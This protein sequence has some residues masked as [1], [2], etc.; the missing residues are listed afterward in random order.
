MK[1]RKFK[2]NGIEI[3]KGSMSVKASLNMTRFEKQFQQAQFWLDG[4]IMNDMVPFM[5]M[6]DDTFID[7]TKMHSAALQGSGKVYA[8]YGPQGR[9]LYEGKVMV[10]ELTK[11]PWARKGARKEVIDKDLK[12][13]RASAKPKWFEEAE[14]LNSSNWIKGVKER[15]G[16]S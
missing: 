1:L 3:N 4:Q 15:A 2:F 10:D 6:Q 9:F 16:G 8:A 12:Y 7:V 11:S 5:P 14:M 13:S